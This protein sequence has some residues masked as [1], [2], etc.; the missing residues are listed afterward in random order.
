MTLVIDASVA[1]K[2]AAKEDGTEAA[3]RLLLMPEDLIAPDLVIPEVCNALWAKLRR[4]EIP[5]YQ[6]EVAVLI[7]SRAFHELVP[8]LPI[9]ARA[10]EIAASLA[11]PAYDCF[12]LALAEARQATMVTADARLLAR[13]AGTGWDGRAVPLAGAGPP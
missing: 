4:G 7:L 6:I 1:C 11:H 10:V 12:Y 2:W 13:V 9:A 8:S 5:Q 3:N